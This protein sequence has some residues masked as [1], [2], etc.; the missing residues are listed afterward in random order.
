MKLKSAVTGL[1]LSLAL[2]S[3]SSAFA[4]INECSD[5]ICKIPS[6]PNSGSQFFQTDLE[7]ESSY[8]DLPSVKDL[9]AIPVQGQ[10]W[11]VNGIIT[12]TFGTWRGGKRYGH[13]H[14]G[15]DIAASHGA[16]IVA[17]LSGT[18]SFVGRKGGYGQTVIIDHGNGI[19]TLYG[20]NSAIHVAEGDHVRKG[21]EIANVGSTGHSTGPHLH[22]E[23]RLEGKPVN[24]LAWTDKLQKKSNL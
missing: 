9:V 12:G 6:Q 3:S 10:F 4:N 21:E 14:A 17:P 22:Y 8:D 7:E 18:V 11:P 1:A 13:V 2:L 5:G 19:S 16:P 20:H 23:V 15:V 24:P